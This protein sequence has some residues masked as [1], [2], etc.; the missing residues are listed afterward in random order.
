MNPFTQDGHSIVFGLK[1]NDVSIVRV[2]CPHDGGS[3]GVCNANRSYCIVRRY[4]FMY[5]TD[6]C[7]GSVIIDGPV[8]IAWLSQEGESDLDP[9][10]GA[11]Y[12]TPVMDSDYQN[13]LNDAMFEEQKELSLASSDIV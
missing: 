11:V 10:I 13:M 8:E 4:L 7:L 5:G 6:L 1:G 3:K 2:D 12:F 9:I